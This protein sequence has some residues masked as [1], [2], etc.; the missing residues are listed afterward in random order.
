MKKQNL[1]KYLLYLLFGGL[2]TLVGWATYAFLTSV[3]HTG[4]NI[5]NIFS[6]ICAVAFA[7]LTNRKMVFES[8]AHSGR[9]QIREFV[10]FLVSRLFTGA[11]EIFGFPILIH[12][13]VNQEIFGIKGMLA[14]MIVTVISVILNYI[15]S[16]VFVFRK[17]K[18]N[19]K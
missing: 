5:S 19:M 10:K 16:N 6:W 3:F 17:N 1:R 7:Y 9:E 18:P 2:T 15:L 12:F 13:G 4:E 11:I 8:R 14:K